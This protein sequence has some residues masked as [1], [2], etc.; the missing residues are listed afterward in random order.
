MLGNVPGTG[1]YYVIYS[2][3]F[4]SVIFILYYYQ[5]ET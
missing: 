1:S 2:A 3:T 4:I 5:G